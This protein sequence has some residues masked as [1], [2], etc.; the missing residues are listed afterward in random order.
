[1]L[2]LHFVISFERF[3]PN[4]LVWSRFTSISSY[5][6][7]CSLLGYIMV[8]M[9]EDI[10]RSKSISICSHAWRGESKREAIFLFNENKVSINLQTVLCVLIFLPKFDINV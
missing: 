2:L 3:F 7:S 5:F 4:L 1:L 10:C 8:S 9:N 6:V